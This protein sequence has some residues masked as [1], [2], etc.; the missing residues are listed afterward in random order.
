MQNQIV[1]LAVI[2][3]LVLD[4]YTLPFNSKCLD[5]ESFV[6]FFGPPYFKYE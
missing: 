3:W 1:H 6:M 4:K 5:K 2:D